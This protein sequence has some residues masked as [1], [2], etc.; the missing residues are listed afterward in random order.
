M[1]A[2]DE[3]TKT[4]PSQIRGRPS[5]TLLT[6]G[7]R[8]KHRQSFGLSQG[9]FV[10]V[11]MLGLSVI[12]VGAWRFAAPV[13]AATVSTTAGQPSPPPGPSSGVVDLASPAPEVTG[14]TATTA[15]CP[16]CDILL[17]TACSLRKDHI[18]AY[19]V[20]P[21]LTPA[22]DEIADGGVRFDRA[23]AASNFTLAS[24][25]AVLTGRFGSSSGVTGW[26]KGLGDGVPTLAEVLGIYG[27]R[28]GAFTVDAPSGFRP[29][30][31]LHRG[32][33]VMKVIPTPRDTPD[34]RWR[35]GPIGPGG[36]SA[37]PVVEWLEDSTKMPQ[38]SIFTM[39][40]TRTAHF[41]FV[42]DEDTTDPTGI[43]QGLWE[44]GR[45]PVAP[46]S[47]GAMPGM[48]GGTSQ[49]GVVELAG[50]DP[51][52]TTL[53]TGGP[54]AEAMWR[55]RYQEA[56]GRMDIDLRRVLDALEAAGRED[57]TII[58]LVGDHGES[59]N[60]H[61]E[62]LHGDA[63]YASVSNVP[64]LMRV[65]GL[66][67]GLAVQGA[68]VS[69][70]DILPTLLELIGATAPAGIDG[71]SMVP[72]LTGQASA[73]RSTTLVEGGGQAEQRRA[74]GGRHHRPLGPSP[75]TTGCGAPPKPGPGGRWEPVD[76]LFDL[77]EDIGQ[78]HNVAADHPDVVQ[79]LLGR[80]S[81][82][83]SAR[84]SSARQF[85]LDPAF[86]EELQRTGYD[87]HKDPVDPGPE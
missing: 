2:W 80:W 14:M 41:P 75:P 34:G 37:A 40:H 49:Q 63:Y 30:Y 33:Q 35:G 79:E 72:L 68:L 47:G 22:A 78:E 86:V 81:A 65:P 61:G 70:V 10:V 32:F 13:P 25:T 29:D 11:G 19:G 51:L 52:Q 84:Q 26:D 4:G 58:V 73:I 67:R 71:V 83:R 77:N 15:L 5:R 46:P 62:M 44:A 12:G 27:Y 85:E 16:G 24:L 23:F 59:L 31:G 74:P 17:I 53:Q 36:A 54:A 48:A 56:V 82:F 43:S 6:V 3:S 66:S 21:A 8:R 55:Q 38:Q 76:C 28:T 20:F 7:P 9:L 60:D 45:T 50:V 39:F 57:R 1:R 64:L 87:L 18:G 42:I 69:H